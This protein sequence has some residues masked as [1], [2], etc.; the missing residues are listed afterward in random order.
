MHG[1]IIVRKFMASKG[2]ATTVAGTT[3]RA[4]QLAMKASVHVLASILRRGTA[5]TYPWAC[6]WRST[7]TLG[8]PK[9]LAE[10]PPGLRAHGRSPGE[11]ACRDWDGVE[12]SCW[13][14]VDHSTLALLALTAHGCHVFSHALPDKMGSHHMLGWWPTLP[15]QSSLSG[16]RT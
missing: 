13:L 7:G 8:L 9:R 11:P 16:K 2:V 1:P 4:T 12:W 15:E 6:Q 10:D 14:L 3:K 5:S